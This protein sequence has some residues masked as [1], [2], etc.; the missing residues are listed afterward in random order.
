MVGDQ[1]RGL[2]GYNYA[3]SSG[4]AQVRYVLQGLSGRQCHTI[5]EAY[6]HSEPPAAF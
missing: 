5:M 4:A 6:P 1:R 3:F 2:D